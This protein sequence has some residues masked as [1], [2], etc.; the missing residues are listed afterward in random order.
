MCVLPTVVSPATQNFHRQ[1]SSCFYEAQ[2]WKTVALCSC[3]VCCY[4]MDVVTVVMLVTV[5]RGSG[6]GGGGAN[7]DAGHNGRNVIKQ[8]GVDVN[9][10]HLIINTVL[11]HTC[12]HTHTH[13]EVKVYFCIAIFHH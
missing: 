6:G 4:G 8:E 3:V 13:S 12:T 1:K 5:V 7:H 10:T 2:Q 11:M 9:E